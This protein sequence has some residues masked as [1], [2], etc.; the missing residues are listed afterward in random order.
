MKKKEKK[1][2]REWKK[3]KKEKWEIVA[4]YCPETKEWLVERKFLKRVLKVVDSS[5]KKS[6]EKLLCPKNKTK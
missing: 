5:V 2:E 3:K 6:L 4:L 1:I